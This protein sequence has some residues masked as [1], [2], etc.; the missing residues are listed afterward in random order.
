MKS[1]SIMFL[2]AFSLNS[3]A[4]T[5][6][7]GKITDVDTGE[8]VIFATVAIY[9][10]GVLKT[11]TETDF[12]GYYSFTELEL[13]EYEIEVTTTGYKTAKF[14]KAKIDKSAAYKFDVKMTAGVELIPTFGCDF[15][16]PVYSQDDTT[17]GH[18]FRRDD[19]KH[20]PARN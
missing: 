7:E 5:R 19:I 6:L 17:Q 13:G 16:P 18:V 12:D 4:Q 14:A 11:G 3:F 1:L 20:S 9:Q 2:L 15:R 10:N 8:S